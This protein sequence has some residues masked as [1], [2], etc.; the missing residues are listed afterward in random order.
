[1]AMKPQLYE[2]LQD[3]REKLK[4][5][6]NK[7]EMLTIIATAT[8]KPSDRFSY[9]NY[10]MDG[11]TWRGYIY[12]PYEMRFQG[13][14]YGSL[15]CLWDNAPFIVRG[16]P[17]ILYSTASGILGRRVHIEEKLDG[18]NLV[19]FRLPNGKLMG[20]TRAVARYDTGGYLGRQWHELAAQ[21][22][23][24]PGIKQLVKEDYYPC[25][26]LYGHLN[27]CEFID[28]PDT[29]IELA[30]L[31]IIDNRDFR[32]LPY[33][34]KKELFEGVGIPMPDLQW[35]GVLDKNNLT[36][37]ENIAEEKMGEYEGFMAKSW[38][39]LGDQMFSK[40]KCH[41]MRELA[42]LRSGGAI[43]ASEIDKSVR[44][45][46]DSIAH[47]SSVGELHA[48]VIEDLYSEW[49]KHYVDASLIRIER[50]LAKAFPVDTF[51]IWDHLDKIDKKIPVTIENKAKVLGELKKRSKT[52]RVNPSGGYHAY[53]MYL[54]KEGRI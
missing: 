21:T 12:N 3:A 23:R 31:D 37:M 2:Q 9:F 42:R 25:V 27:R 5:V 39:P 20:K 34:Q 52:F 26:E 36:W 8:R 51:R 50:T 47:I 32:F 14:L 13:E 41:A 24:L 53:T 28:Y 17:K 43:P 1:M 45:A 10:D 4:G 18:T 7:H 46:L 44:K 49:D 6:K 29:P 30:G 19:F 48:M 35:E 33:K 38:N 11:H 54:R 15:F 16:Y 22:D 40:I